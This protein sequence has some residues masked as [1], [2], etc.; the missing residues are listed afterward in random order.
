MRSSIV[1]SKPTNPQMVLRT[2]FTFG[3][4]LDEIIRNCIRYW[5]TCGII[6]I[7]SPS[8]ATT[9]CVSAVSSAPTVL[10]RRVAVS[11]FGSRSSLPRVLRMSFGLKSKVLSSSATFIIM[12]STPLSHIPYRLRRAVM[13]LPRKC[14]ISSATVRPIIGIFLS[15]KG[16]CRR[17]FLLIILP[18][19]I[20]K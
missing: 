12:W 20:C 3:I 18:N 8:F 13:I 4:N 1:F 14:S 10:L 7:S 15:W 2:L 5:P 17:S 9:K 11:S 16:M 6:S 19:R